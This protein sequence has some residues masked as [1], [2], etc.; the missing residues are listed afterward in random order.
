MLTR[1]LS[2]ARVGRGRGRWLRGLRYA[3]MAMRLG[4][5]APLL[6]YGTHMSLIV[7]VISVKICH[8]F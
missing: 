1:G 7:K 2:G 4:D 3:G 5:G 8:F 6:R